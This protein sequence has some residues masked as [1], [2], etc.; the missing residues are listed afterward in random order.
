[1]L[2]TQLVM[3]IF[4][5]QLDYKWIEQQYRNGG[6]VVIQISRQEDY[7]PSILMLRLEDVG[8]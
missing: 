2:L 4:G 8:F 6:T 1:M 3:T 5:Y 7:M